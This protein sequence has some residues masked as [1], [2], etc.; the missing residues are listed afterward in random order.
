V[1]FSAHN[2]AHAAELNAAVIAIKK[3]RPAFWQTGVIDQAVDLG[4][5]VYM[6]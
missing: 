5:A 1:L 4:W 6:S 3:P 2:L